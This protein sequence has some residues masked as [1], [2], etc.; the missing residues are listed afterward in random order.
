M[1]FLSK[2][3]NQKI[4]AY[5][6]KPILAFGS[7]SVVAQLLSMIYMLILARY[8]GPDG[9]GIYITPFT[10]SNLS[11]IM[12]N[13][14][15]D[16]WLLSSDTD[17]TPILTTTGNVFKLKLITGAIWGFLLIILA[18]TLRP[19]LYP[20]LLLC[21]IIID[22]WAESL[23]HTLLA[24]LNVARKIKLYSFMLLLTRVT[25]V[26]TL[27]FLVIFNVKSVTV[28]A[29][30][31]TILT[32]LSMMIA[33]FLVKPTK[34]KLIPREGIEIMKAAQPF[35]FSEIL[36]IIY[37]QADITLL[38]LIKSKTSAGIYSPVSS[39]INALF[40]IPSSI[41]LY[42]IPVLSRAFKNNLKQY[43]G[44]TSKLYIGL[45]ILGIF[46]TAG[47][48]LIGSRL[49]VLLLGESYSLAGTLIVILSPILFIKSLEFGFVTNIIAMEK[50]NSRLVPQIISAIVNISFNL[51]AI[52][53]Y[54]ETGAAISYI[55]SELVLF[56]S[57]GGVFIFWFR[58]STSEKLL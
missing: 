13:L 22:V 8:L 11:A 41:H 28:I 50:Q 12:F 39:L 53:R 10:I 46:M 51:W 57:Y 30:S 44:L 21:L 49:V 20:F 45:F 34:K 52:P 17:K 29:A 7:S 6:T 9:Y 33:L 35:A 23:I 55:I 40:I 47:I 48:G 14:G 16:T 43:K 54:G 38:S 24:A 27:V 42:S 5:I 15:L 3:R 1:N 58:K 25:R 18:P 32:V 36:S 56:V 26:I 37:M 4:E 2:L 31:R 19:D